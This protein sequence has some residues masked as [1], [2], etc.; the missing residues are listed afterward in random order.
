M[1]RIDPSS[2][3]I[4]AINEPLESGN[5]SQVIIIFLY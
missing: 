5:W 4:F 3:L 1:A 2:V